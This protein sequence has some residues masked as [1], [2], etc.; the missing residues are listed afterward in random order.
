MTTTSDRTGCDTEDM[1]VIHR[2]FRRLFRDGPVLV[3]NVRPGDDEHRRPVVDHLLQLT[4]ALHN[5]HRTE[6][7]HLWDRL[8]AKAPGCAVHVRLMQQQ[9][10]AMAERLT[11]ADRVLTAWRGSGSEADAA[12]SLAAMSEVLRSLDEHLGDEERRILPEASRAMTQKEWDVIGR[13]ARA[14]KTHVPE[15]VQPVSPMVQLGLM[16]DGLDEQGLKEVRRVLPRPAIVLY[17]L[18]GKRRFAAYRKKVYGPAA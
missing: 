2:M 5:H 10:A 6:D 12:A 18:L 17:T 15:F 11:D 4:A 3:G 9:H 14:E 1:V 13:V 7:E 16:L 8:T